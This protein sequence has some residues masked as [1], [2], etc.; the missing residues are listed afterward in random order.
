MQLEGFS[1]ITGIAEISR[2]YPIPTRDKRGAW[3]AVARRLSKSAAS[4][5]QC[6][7]PAYSVW[8]SATHEPSHLVATCRKAAEAG[9]TRSRAMAD[10][11]RST[12]GSSATTVAESSPADSTRLDPHALRCALC[13]YQPDGST[14]D[15]GL[16]RALGVE[17]LV[18]MVCADQD[19]CVTRFA[20]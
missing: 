20:Q 4:H 2:V 9:G 5:S 8:I 11:Q 17:P 12:D 7:H 3:V 10:K 14:A 1:T 13:G 15:S 6:A 18:V 16:L 19:A